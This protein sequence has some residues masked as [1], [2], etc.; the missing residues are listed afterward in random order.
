MII[1]D[2][3]DQLAERAQALWSRVQE[4]SAYIQLRERFE[5]LSPNAQKGVL[6]G[7][8]AF[9]VFIVISIPWSYFSSSSDYV[10]EF[11]EKRE[12]IRELYQV[13]REATAVSTGMDPLDGSG[14][15][16]RAQNVLTESRIG[17]EQNLGVSDYPVGKPP[18]DPS[19]PAS[20]VQKGAEVKVAKLNLQQ[21]VD[22]GYKLQT[23]HPSVKMTG[24]EVEANREDPHYFNV[25]YKI[26]TFAIPVQAPPAPKG[27]IPP[28]KGGK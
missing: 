12:L 8:A 7:G 21:I 10:T 23:I 4:S 19:I 25:I 3:K 24:L 1:D 5:N 22:I 11:E 26:V 2:I 18:A 9:L 28:R 20:V 15:R 13:N 27:K 14:L 16:D 6:I 17:A